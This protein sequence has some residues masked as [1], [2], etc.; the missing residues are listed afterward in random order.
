M[1]RL[2]IVENLILD[3]ADV[4]LLKRQLE[5]E[6][7]YLRERVTFYEDEVRKGLKRDENSIKEIFSLI[8]SSLG[9][10]EKEYN[11]IKN[12]LNNL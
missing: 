3:M 11:G 5:Q 6:N 9:N 7:K 1:E 8:S 2:E 10:K 12:I 4:V